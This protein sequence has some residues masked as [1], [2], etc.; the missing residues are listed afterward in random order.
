MKHYHQTTNASPDELRRFQ[1]AA[2]T[3]DGKVLDW[4]LAHRGQALTAS[5][6]HTGMLQVGVIP[7]NTPLTSIRR[8]ISNLSGGHQWATDRKPRLVKTDETR[9]GLYG[10]REHAYRLVTGQQE[11]PL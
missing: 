9:M 2:K 10:R 4:F 11:L 8:A 1:T 6:V 5:Q 3:Q 7:I